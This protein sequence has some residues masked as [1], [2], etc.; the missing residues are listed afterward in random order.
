M[1]F[2]WAALGAY[3]LI[4]RWRE[5]ASITDRSRHSTA[6]VRGRYHDD[7]DG[8]GSSDESQADNIVTP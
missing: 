7:G 6:T 3:A 4:N 5:R 1:S 8:C 2:V